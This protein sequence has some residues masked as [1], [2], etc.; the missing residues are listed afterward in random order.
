MH[1]SLIK[2]G[3]STPVLSSIED[4]M[5]LVEDRNGTSLNEWLLAQAKD[6]SK[7]ALIF[8]CQQGTFNKV[9]VIGRHFCAHDFQRDGKLSHPLVTQG[10]FLYNTIFL[11][12]STPTTF[13]IPGS[14]LVHV[15]QRLDMLY[16]QICFHSS[17]PLRPFLTPIAYK[18]YTSSAIINHMNTKH[19]VLNRKPLTP[20]LSREYNRQVCF[21]VVSNLLP[22]WVVD[23]E[24]FRRILHSST[25][26]HR[27]SLS[28]VHLTSLYDDFKLSLQSAI[29]DCHLHI[30]FDLWSS[31]S[32]NHYVVVSC[33]WISKEWKIERAGLAILGLDGQCAKDIVSAVSNV[34]SNIGINQKMVFSVITDGA[35]NEVSAATYDDFCEEA[36]HVWCYLHKLNLII[37]DGF[38]EKAC[39][40]S[41]TSREKPT[42]SV[43]SD[44]TFYKQFRDLNPATFVPYRRDKSRAEQHVTALCEASME[45]DDDIILDSNGEDGTDNGKEILLLDTLPNSCEGLWR[46]VRHISGKFRKSH[47]YK[48]ILKTSCESVGIQ[49]RQPLLYAR[50][51][52]IGSYYEIERFNYL[53][54]A[55]LH[56]I[57]GPLRD[58]LSLPESFF[59]ACKEL[60]GVLTMF[61]VPMNDLQASSKPTVSYQVIVTR[62]LHRY[63][64]DLKKKSTYAI[65]S[66]FCDAIV[67]SIVKRFNCFLDTTVEDNIEL[68]PFLACQLL[69]PTTRGH[70]TEN[71]DLSVTLTSYACEVHRNFPM[72]VQEQKEAPKKKRKL[73][74]ETPSGDGHD[75]DAR[76]TIRNMI[77]GSGDE[78]P[79][80]HSVQETQDDSMHRALEAEAKQYIHYVLAMKNSM[81]ALDF[82]KAYG[83]RF[84][85]LKYVA[86]IV[87]GQPCGSYDTER[88]C[89]DA[90][91]II[92]KKRN[93]LCN[94][95]IDKTWM[96]YCNRKE[97]WA[98]TSPLLRDL[99]HN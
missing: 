45:D 99:Y 47:K 51:R 49:F 82:W 87:L 31:I 76:A 17:T 77:F 96:I 85:L 81:N 33:Q 20:A 15:F 92:T 91:N 10:V 65:V 48:Q 54:K 23:D 55:I 73:N 74:Q 24:S 12:S 21:A 7:P 14:T 97:Q 72:E 34:I 3:S 58:S 68:R 56:A 9:E 69:D 78:Q 39:R 59:P 64:N 57:N 44:R 62:T 40:S 43:S 88:K 38:A 86:R 63:V 19:S 75:I 66:R 18:N 1:V 98:T 60:E 84:P 36:E 42:T 26:P 53:S 6:S 35:S 22:F 32:M 67:H 95:K 71:S 4:L 79:G 8:Y 94:E 29:Q 30:A 93:R 2:Q 52:W 70:W 80:R 28:T 89:S 5:G 16:C 83:D 25:V 11:P 50:T 46:S 90:G 41:A 27:T 13:G 37:G 61:C